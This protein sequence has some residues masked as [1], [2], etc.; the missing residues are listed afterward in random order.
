MLI[1]ETLFSIIIIG[2]AVF[3]L[4]IGVLFFGKTSERKPCGESPHLSEKDCP[5]R[6]AGLCPIENPSEELAI[7]K[8][9]KL[10]Y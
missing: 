4:S 8:R 2:I 3:F 5:S 1:F 10:N 6:K 9:G 7:L